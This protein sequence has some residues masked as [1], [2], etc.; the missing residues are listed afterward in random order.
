M[1]LLDASYRQSGKGHLYV[2]IY[3]VFAFACQRALH[4]RHDGRVHPWQSVRSV[5]F[6]DKFRSL[7]FDGNPV[8]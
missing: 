4:V 2:G 1:N 7:P 5:D 6:H 8:W 3:E